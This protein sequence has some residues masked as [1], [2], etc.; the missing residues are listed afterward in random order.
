M[1]EEIQFSVQMTAGEVYQFTIYHLYHKFSGIFGVCLSLMA[2]II[3]IT[4]FDSLTDQSRVILTLVALWFTILAPVILFFR[5]KGQ[6]KRNK[7]YQKPLNY[8]LDHTGIT[9]SQDDAKQTIEW[10]NLM[11]IVETKSQFLIYSS[12]IHAFVFPKKAV[13]EKC[14]VLREMLIGYTEKTNVRLKGMKM[15]QKED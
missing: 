9:V 2:F 4:S 14:S 8:Q 13:G 1:K 5:S 3:L 11:K 10:E 6:V 7:S 12:N 15:K